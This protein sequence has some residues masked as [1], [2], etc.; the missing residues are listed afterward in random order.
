MNHKTK[1]TTI[2]LNFLLQC[3][4]NLLH[5][6]SALCEQRALQSLSFYNGFKLTKCSNFHLVSAPITCT[7]LQRRSRS[8]AVLHVNVGRLGTL[9]Y[10]SFRWRAVRMFNKLPKH[11]RMISSCSVDK[12][13]SQFDKHLRNIS[14]M[15]CQPGHNNILDGRD[16]LNVGHYAD[17]QAAN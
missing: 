11:I 3:A 2:T 12:F 16:C 13:K 4:M 8:C 15:P 7:Y 17:A 6:M 5:I 1:L 10:N 9:C 14:D